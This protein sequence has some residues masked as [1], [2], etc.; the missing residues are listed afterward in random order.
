M[1]VT[2]VGLVGLISKKP[3]GLGPHAWAAFALLPVF[4]H[5]PD[6]ELV[7]LCNS[8]LESARRAIE[9]Y[10]LPSSVKAY[11]NP[12]DLAK[13][14]DVDLVVISVGVGKH[15]QIAKPALLEGK[16]VFV[17]WPLG[18]S[19]E[20]AEILTT[21]ARE[22]NIKTIVGVQA[23]AD[24][25]I[26]KVREI[27]QSGKLGKIT[28]SNVLGSTSG[29]PSHFWFNGMDYYLDIKSGGNL[30]HI[31][32]GHF[33]DSF[34]YVLGDFETLQSDLKTEIT[35]IPV[36][37]D[38]GTLTEPLKKNTPDHVLVQGRL[39]SGAMASIAYRWCY[40]Q[41][42]VGD[43]GIRWIVS[44]TEGELELTTD[45]GSWQMNFPNRK[46]KLRLRGKPEE[47]VD[48]SV[49][50]AGFVQNMEYFGQNSGRILDA[51]ANGDQTVY[52]DFSSATQTHKLLDEI[53][54]KSAHEL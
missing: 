2:R 21:L 49:A 18:A 5:S 13:D 53:L 50:N 45:Q 19:T 15:F 30:Y 11:G 46:L 34:T 36:M 51:F 12:E 7:A 4:L 35:E 25:L 42:A 14:P 47:D 52:A 43:V 27:V 9:A 24:P 6:Y 22:K 29:L 39:K 32:F 20:E 38:D 1:A 54:K 26:L 31:Y 17:E 10:E 40:L 28:S 16:K 3:E 48:F 23:R 37:K 41:E 8:S 44:G 33:L